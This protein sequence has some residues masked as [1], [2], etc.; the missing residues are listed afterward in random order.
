MVLA[1]RDVLYFYGSAAGSGPQAGPSGRDG[2]QAG[3]LPNDPAWLETLRGLSMPIDGAQITRRDYQMPGS[4]RH[5]RL[6]VHEGIDFYTATSGVTIDGRTPVHAVAAGK[7]IR[8]MVDYRPLTAAQARAWA[9]QVAGLGYTPPDVLD[10]YRGRQVWIEHAN[11][12]VSHYAH[13]SAIAPG[14]S[15]GA[16]VEQG[17]V[18]GTVGN[19]GTPESVSN[20]SGELHLHLELW[21][22]GNY[23]GQFLRPIE[24]RE[25]IEGILR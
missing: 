15:V 3:T 7:V 12:L 19:S 10:G 21:G 9:A 4:P 23:V 17:Q 1:G 25:W 22:G 8:A 2:G 6:G 11:G 5:Y 14:I 18:I 13:L 24:V 16:L 20:P